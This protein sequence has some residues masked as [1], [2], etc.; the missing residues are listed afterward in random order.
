M[1][2]PYV[3][4]YYTPTLFRFERT[5]CAQKV[6]FKNQVPSIVEAALKVAQQKGKPPVVVP[7]WLTLH[8]PERYVHDNYAK[9][10][11]H[12]LTGTPFENT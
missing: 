11:D 9:C 7:R 5:S 3:E 10:V 12:L 1:S 2:Y 4:R 6:G 8:D